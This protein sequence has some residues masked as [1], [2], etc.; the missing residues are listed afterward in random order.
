MTKKI[1]SDST[2]LNVTNT[3]AAMLG[4]Q[5]SHMI[6]QPLPVNKVQK[7]IT[8]D[9]HFERSHTSGGLNKVTE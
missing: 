4:D 8:K 9:L 6:Q 5:S 2:V 1:L 3:S 7:K